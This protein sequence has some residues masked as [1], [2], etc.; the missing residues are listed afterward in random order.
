MK[1]LFEKSVFRVLSALICKVVN[2]AVACHFLSMPYGQLGVSSRP[3]VNP[4]REN[5]SELSMSWEAD[6]EA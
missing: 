3:K 2:I 4:F 5:H 6:T 1:I